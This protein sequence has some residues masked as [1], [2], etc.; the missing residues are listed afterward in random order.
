MKEDQYNYLALDKGDKREPLIDENDINRN[1][2]SNVL[3]DIKTISNVE[4]EY[5]QEKEDEV[6]DYKPQQS[7]SSDE[8]SSHA[9]KNANIYKKQQDEAIR[10]LTW[11]C[12]ICTIFMIIE[13][14]GGYLANSIAIMSDA[15][16]LLSDL[17]GF[18]ISIISIY[19]SRKIAKNDMSYGYHRA[20]IIGALVSIVL[21]WALTIWLLYEATLRI[22]VTPK[23]D[24]LIMI[25]ISI[26]G[27]SFNVIMGLV[28]AKS[29]VPHSHGLHGHDHDHDHDHD[30]EHELE[31]HHDSD[32]EE[33]GLHDEN[34]HSNT[35]V[36]LRASFIHI[37]GDAL[38]NVGV[39]IAGGIIF[40]FPTFCIADPICT[41]IFSIIVG[42]TTIRI[43]KDCIFVLM[44]GSPVAVDIEQLEKDLTAIPGVKEIHDLHVWSLSIGKMSLSCHICTDDPQKTLKKATKMIQKKYKIDHVTIQVEDNKDKNQISCKNDLH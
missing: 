31:H 36:N 35:N 34:E 2:S 28:L 24:G 27:F 33:I 23:V 14:I 15:A 21:I 16:H 17:L 25:I 41:Y 40:L 39:L 5:L 43:L 32:D 30:H 10:K 38:Q 8:D 37:L 4:T 11:V 42:L 20:E 1:D 13:I 6:K 3:K 22:I 12:V 7:S 19:I 18:L 9:E 44:E 29:G 26:I